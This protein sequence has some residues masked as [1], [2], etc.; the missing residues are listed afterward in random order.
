MANAEITCMDNRSG[1]N[2]YGVAIH[3]DGHYSNNKS[4][5]GTRN[6]FFFEQ[7]T[8]NYCSHS[9]SL[10]CDA[11]VVIR[12]CTIKNADSY[13]DIHG[14]TYNSCYYSPYWPEQNTG[15]DGGGGYEIYDN[16][17]MDYQASWHISPRAGSAGIITQN[18]FDGSGTYPVCVQAQETCQNST[19]CG[20]GGG[21]TCNRVYRYGQRGCLQMLENWFIWDNETISGRSIYEYK[22]RNCDNCLAEGSGYVTRAP[23]EELDGFTWTPYTYPHPL[24][25]DGAIPSRNS[26]PTA[27]PTEKSPNH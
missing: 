6:A 20:E 11:L 10:F 25:S 14:P 13:I 12:K 17:F 1:Q 2:P 22:N 24:V 16:D 7:V 8:F 27:K 21:E 15:E 26:R 18:R 19:G 5:L 9:V 3:G 23:T 4:R